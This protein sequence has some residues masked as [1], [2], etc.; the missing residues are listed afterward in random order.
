MPVWAFPLE[1]KA[2]AMR[3]FCRVGMAALWLFLSLT[4][5]AQ[6]CAPFEFW[7]VNQSGEGNTIAI[8]FVISNT[9]GAVET[10]GEWKVYAAD[11]RLVHRERT[12][13]QAGTWNVAAWPCGLYHAI[14][15]AEG[16]QPLRQQLVVF[17]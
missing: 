10:E 2:N 9:D 17:R 16:L 1:P 8:D 13:A 6:E 14:F 3:I 5:W 7:V 15:V 11:G 12:M 4:A